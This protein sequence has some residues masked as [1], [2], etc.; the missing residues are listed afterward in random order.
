MILAETAGTAAII[1]AIGGV[2]VSLVTVY[3]NSKKQATD[4]GKNTGQIEALTEQ[5]A[6]LAI[7]VSSL[8]AENAT[9]KLQVQ[10]LEA[11]KP[12]PVV[13]EEPAPA[14]KPKKKPAAKKPAAKKKEK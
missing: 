3:L 5:I 8:K 11:Q 2:G 9:L 6:T 4:T 13:E 10:L 12:A 1:T 7:Q 14:P